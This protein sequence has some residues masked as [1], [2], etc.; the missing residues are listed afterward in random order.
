MHGQEKLV[1]M[2]LKG[3]VPD[4]VWFDM[5]TTNV[6][7]QA[8]DWVDRDNARAQI[9]LDVG[10]KVSRLDVRFV[11]G[12]PVWIDGMCQADVHELRD[13]CKAMG[14]SRVIA[15]VMKRYGS[16]EFVSFKCVDMSDTAGFFTTPDPELMH[17]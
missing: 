2:R 12:L 15:S 3:V 14:A 1:E 5:D 11:R 9:Q 16:G 7:D 10:D 6:I 8:K 4:W 17:G 13:K